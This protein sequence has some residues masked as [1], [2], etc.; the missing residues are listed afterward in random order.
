MRRPPVV[1]GGLSLVAALAAGLVAP[2]P[3][4]AGGCAL[5]A[6]DSGGSPV[7]L[8]VG[9]VVTIEGF[10]FTLGDV[11]LTFTVDGIELRTETVT[12]A[13]EF[14]NTGYF[15]LNVTLRDGDEGQWEVAATEVEGSC[16]ATTGF[17]V[18]PGQTPSPTAGPPLPDVATTPPD[19]APPWGWVLG[20]LLFL[21]AAARALIGRQTM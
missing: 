13:D 10:N 3:T 17:P 9:D 12:A 5:I 15:I 14:G 20:V 19:P 2:A 1:L 16:A 8:A 21:A 6:T 18:G 7:G 4:T 11:V